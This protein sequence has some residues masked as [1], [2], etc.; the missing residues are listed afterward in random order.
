MP[1]RKTLLQAVFEIGAR[2]LGRSEQAEVSNA[3]EK[4]LPTQ[5]R[6][7]DNATDK[8]KRQTQPSSKSSWTS[9]IPGLLIDQLETKDLPISLAVDAAIRAE[10]YD[11]ALKLLTRYVTI[12]LAPQGTADNLSP[13]VPSSPSFLERFFSSVPLPVRI[14]PVPQLSFLGLNVQRPPP[15]PGQQV[16]CPR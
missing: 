7:E 15:G 11:L 4:S 13:F 16:H 1:S 2:G 9:L 10:N 5:Q 3:D 14:P 12:P 8:K 6:S